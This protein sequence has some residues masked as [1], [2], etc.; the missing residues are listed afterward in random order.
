LGYKT[1]EQSV[2]IVKNKTIS[3]KLFI[4]KDSKVLKTVEISAERQAQKTQIKTSVIKI[5]PQQMQKIPTIGGE[6]DIAQYLQILPGVVSS[7]D[8][9]GQLYI[10]GGAPIQNK[11]LMDGMTIYNPFHSIGFFSV[12]DADII[13]TADVYTGGFNAQYGGRISSIMDFKM[14]DGNKKNFEGKF[15]RLFYTI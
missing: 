1:L 6:P 9:G 13:S 10:R 14:R 8:Q 4:E 3:V 2:T 5:S 12:F 7:G 11:V 15:E